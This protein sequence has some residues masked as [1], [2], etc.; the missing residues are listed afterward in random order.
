MIASLVVWLVVVVDVWVA[1]EV[2]ANK[3]ENDFHFYS[4]CG[5]TTYQGVGATSNR[6][7]RK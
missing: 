7:L 2:V 6:V 3:N 1:R 4:E 5:L